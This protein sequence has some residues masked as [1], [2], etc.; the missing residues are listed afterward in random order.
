MNEDFD[1]LSKTYPQYAA[2]FYK[3]ETLPARVDHFDNSFLGN[4]CN[5]KS[6]QVFSLVVGSN[7]YKLLYKMFPP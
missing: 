2:I 4:L 1:C 7:S 6:H 3:S 5:N